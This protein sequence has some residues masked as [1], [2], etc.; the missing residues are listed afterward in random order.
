MTALSLQTS[1]SLSVDQQRCNASKLGRAAGSQS[2][3]TLQQALEGWT[4]AELD[5]L[6]GKNPLHM[7]A[8]QGCI[9]NVVFLVE[10]VGC[11]VNSISTAEFSYGK[12]PIFF[13]ATKCR[14]DV[15]LYLLEQGAC[16][17]IVNNKGQSVRSIASSHLLPHVIER[18]CHYEQLQVQWTNYRATH[19]DSLEYGDLDPRFLDRP[20][21]EDDIVTEHAVNP[22]TKQSRQGSFLRKN[23]HLVVKPKTHTNNRKP[24]RKPP[25]NALSAEETNQVKDAWICV[26]ELLKRIDVFVENDDASAL[27]VLQQDIRMIVQLSD[28]QKGSWIPEAAQR[29]QSLDTDS[30]RI[31]QYLAS[32]SVHDDVSKR[33]K[34]LLTKLVAEMLGTR[35]SESVSEAATVS[36]DSSHHS[37]AVQALILDCREELDAILAHE[38]IARFQSLT[39]GMDDGVLHLPEPPHWVDSVSDELLLLEDA[40]LKSRVAAIDTEWYNRSDGTI[41]VA[42]LQIAIPGQVRPWV[43]DLLKDSL[44]FQQRIKHMVQCILFDP[45]R[46]I[47]GFAMGNDLPKLETWL[48]AAL[49]RN[50]CL[51]VQLLHGGEQLN[52]LARIVQL[53][54]DFELSKKEQC[55]SWSDRPLSGAQMQYAGLDA[56]V[57]PALVAEWLRQAE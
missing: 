39:Y 3:E 42:T 36:K 57:L 44:E 6:P 19:S 45:S 1:S 48:D 51:D 40:L 35:R 46:L 21:R 31:A 8:W 43:L 5:D 25:S 16:V 15:V 13:A 24:R 30:T 47:F 7:A 53:Y 26:L 14:D 33:E 9:E 55:S 38:S 32:L 10:H 49:P 23:P 50:V 52:G 29:L 56:A 34:V 20:L 2:L 54:S 18:I 27:A 17:T 37:Q 12:T 41:H 4:V 22:T 28:K 11:N